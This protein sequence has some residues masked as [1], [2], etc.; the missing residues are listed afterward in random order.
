MM[1][2]L[3]NVYIVFAALMQ[4]VFGHPNRPALQMRQENQAQEPDLEVTHEGTG[5]LWAN[6]DFGE[7]HSSAL[8]ARVIPS[9]TRDGKNTCDKYNCPKLDGLYDD[10]VYKYLCD[11]KTKKCLCWDICIDYTFPFGLNPNDPS[12]F[13]NCVSKMMLVFSNTATDARLICS[14]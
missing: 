3:K 12:D 1:P 2:S 6:V 10:G 4:T 14:S 7:V 13:D 11:K 5:N 9:L 8:Y